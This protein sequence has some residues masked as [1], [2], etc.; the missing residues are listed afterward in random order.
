MASGSE[1]G[2]LKAREVV[3]VPQP[4]LHKCPWCSKTF[5]NSQGRGGHMANHHKLMEAKRQNEE[6]AN[7]HNKLTMELQ[8]PNE[9]NWSG[10]GMSKVS[11]HEFDFISMKVDDTLHKEVGSSGWLSLSL[12]MDHKK[13]GMDDKEDLDTNGID[14]T[15]KL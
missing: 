13:L 12:T 10:Y 9:A 11:Q 5:K 14:L 8:P 2:R 3:P 7:K 15:L 6:K 4:P 1:N